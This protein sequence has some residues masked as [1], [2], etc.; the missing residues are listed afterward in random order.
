MPYLLIRHKVRDFDSWKTA[1][2]QHSSARANAG[3]TELHLLRTIADP[4]D[5][6][7]LFQAD[8]LERARA[9]ARSDDL[10]QKMQDAGVV[11]APEMVELK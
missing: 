9:F 7:L 6:V 1:Y 5:I 4:N 2:D 8:D 11:S 3:L 10:K